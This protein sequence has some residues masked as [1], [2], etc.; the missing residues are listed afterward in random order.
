MLEHEGNDV[1]GNVSKPPFNFTLVN[2]HNNY[3]VKTLT[4]RY[5]KWLYR[6]LDLKYVIVLSD[7]R[8]TQKYSCRSHAWGSVGQGQGGQKHT[9]PRHE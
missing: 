1:A 7:A 5:P 3:S 9:R 4:S 2:Q 6:F 8:F